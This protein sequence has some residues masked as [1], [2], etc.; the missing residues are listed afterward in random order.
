MFA[1]KV[2]VLPGDGIC[3]QDDDWLVLDRPAGMSTAALTDWLRLHH[4]QDTR[5]ASNLEVGAG[6]L[7]VLA[8]RSLVK[9]AASPDQTYVYLSDRCG[10]DVPLRQGHGYYLYGMSVKGVDSASVRKHAAAAGA[11]ILGDTR[12]RGAAFPRL[13][14]HCTDIRWPGVA[15]R[16]HV[17]VPD[18]M[19]GLLAGQDPLLIAAA[20]AIERR[21]CLLDGVTDAHRVIHRGEVR[22]LPFSV[23]RYGG[24]LCVTGFDEQIPSSDLYHGLRPALDYLGTHYGCRGG[25]V[26]TNRLNPHKRKLFADISHFGDPPPERYWVREHGLQYEVTLNDSR[27]TGLFLDQRDS[28]RRVALAARNKRVANLFAFTCSFSSVAVAAGAE[29]V[30]SVD[31][32]GGCLDRGKR[33]FARSGLVESN[34]G[35]FIKEDVRKWLERQNRRKADDPSAFPGWD[36]VV[37]DPPVF[38]S[39]GKGQTFQVEKEW[40]VLTQRIADVLSDDAVALFANNHRSGDEAHYS[41]VLQAHFRKVTQL[42]APLDFPELPNQSP[43]VR[44]YWCESPRR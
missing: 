39:S 19:D 21:A 41:D 22:G 3:Y 23:D 15:R 18:S 35:K 4:G 20:V 10:T 31:L 44:I 16:F 32:A 28:R 9:S 26:K 7:T 38:A 42:P 37:C 24:W 30:F 27:H 12:N 34:R 1:G 17:D 5:D 29:V 8:R 2:T 43:H 11:P 25:V 36:L 40:P 14:L 6:G 13:A 33:N